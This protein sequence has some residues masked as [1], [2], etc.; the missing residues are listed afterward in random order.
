MGERGI[1][2]E[3]NGLYIREEEISRV[4]SSS[5]NYELSFVYYNKQKVEAMEIHK[6]KK[7]DKFFYHVQAIVDHNFFG[8]VSLDIDEDGKVISYDCHCYYCNEES[9]CAHVGSVLYEIKHYRPKAFTF[10]LNSSL[11]DW[12]EAQELRNLDY[13]RKTEQLEQQRRL[14]WVRDVHSSTNQWLIECKNQIHR[15]ILQKSYHQ[16]YH[17]KVEIKPYKDYFYQTGFE[18]RFKIGNDK[19]YY[20][21]NV[22]SFL[23]GL[24]ERGV[25]RYGKHLEVIYDIKN[26]DEDSQSV[27]ELMRYCV[28]NQKLDGFYENNRSIRLNEKNLDEV[29]ECLYQ[30][31]LER[32]NVKCEERKLGLRVDLSKGKYGYELSLLD[33]FDNYL[34]GMHYLYQIEDDLF[35]RYDFGKAFELFLRLQS[36]ERM[37]IAEKDLEMFKK[38]VLEVMQENLIL[39]N[40]IDE[41][42]NITSKVAGLKLFGDIDDHNGI[43]FYIEAIA[44]GV[45]KLVAFDQRNEDIPLELEIVEE[46]IRHF[47]RVI[48]YDAHLAYFDDDSDDTYFF[49]NEGLPYLS[50]YCEIYVSDALQHYG[51]STSIHLSIGVKV[52]HDLLQVDI[53]S[54]DLKADEVVEVLKAYRRKKKYHRLNNG[55]LIFLNEKEMAELDDFSN[56][57]NLSNKEMAQGSVELPMYRSYTLDELAKNNQLVQIERSESFK[58]L[59]TQL[60]NGGSEQVFNC[61][62][63]LNDILRDYQKE[64]YQW[65]KK[66]SC[67]GF[68]GILAD[69]MGLGKTLQMIAYLLSEKGKGCSIVI[70]PASLLLNWADEIMKFAPD[71]KY[72]CVNGN[73][74][75]REGLIKQI[76][77]FDVLITSYDYIRRDIDLYE[78]KKFH[79]IIL[80]EAQFIKN[81]RTK[82][83]QSVKVLKGKHRFALSGTP[84]ENSLAELW[85]IFDFLMPNYLYNYH[86]FQTHFEKQIIRESDEKKQQ[87]LQRLVHPFILRRTKQE[88]LKELP[89]K[90]E[91]TIHVEF[92]EENRKLYMANLVQVNKDLQMHLKDD[93]I[94][95]VAVLAMLTRLRQ[96]CCEPRLLYENI[97]ERSTKLEACMEL[98]DRLVENRQKVLL[99]SSFTSVLD[100]VAEELVKRGI[101]YHLLTG[102]TDKQRRR[103]MVQQFQKD[104]IPVFLISL[105]AGG[106]GLNL[107]AA[108]SVI[109]FDPWWNLSA[110]NQ[111]SD[112]AHRI[113]QS[114]VVQVFKLIMKDSIEE[115][116]QKLQQKKKDIADIFVQGDGAI[117]KMSMDE[118][119]DLFKVE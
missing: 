88:V 95:K 119:V 14:E 19:Y 58:Q 114:E 54:F 45:D 28:L 41:G 115:K 16:T 52:E 118:I 86:Y 59:I 116:I 44:E 108:S 104:D 109:H 8:E 9:A 61:P 43:Y 113:G 101:A 50:Q 105:K 81:Q 10:V 6:V 1:P 22:M 79:A 66:M 5:R 74:K 21:K 34:Q 73:A 65:L 47:A 40:Q 69:D 85:S 100:L 25:E 30:L 64:G 70:T 98:I 82:N 72:G 18:M 51:R 111:A 78:G 68:G 2:M 110:E 23:E 49:M 13:Q 90:I 87:K 7:G 53:K 77:E 27:I 107:T 33:S 32:L 75:K 99:F 26:F 12:Y 84:I 80:D 112:R 93:R 24:N 48:D 31:P 29:Y 60:S 39:D 17:L 35:I 96:I 4:V 46:Y 63:E 55:K 102:S 71:L 67:Y 103:D 62:I 11:N 117:G 20:I 37:M 42:K 97:H 57:L 94:D 106:T 3:K 91:Q 76:D 92:S 56:D 38:Y 83:A 36:M 15:S 89:K